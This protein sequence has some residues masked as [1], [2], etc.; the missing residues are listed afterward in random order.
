[1]TLLR[2]PDVIAAKEPLGAQ[3]RMHCEVA[4][5]ELTAAQGCTRVVI[6]R[7]AEIRVARN[8]IGT[9]REARPRNRIHHRAV[10]AAEHELPVASPMDREP[11]PVYE[12][13]VIA[14]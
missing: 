8:Q 2:P 6:D 11:A 12:A 13:M 4:I 1:M 14:T 7:E 10:G 9:V 3:Q 5:H